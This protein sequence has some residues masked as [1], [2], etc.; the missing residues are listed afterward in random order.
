MDY[1][2]IAPENVLDTLRKYMLVDGFDIVMDL[3]NSQGSYV[4]DLRTGHK[5]LDFFTCIASS[6][7]G[8]NHPKMTTKEFLEKL[9]FIAVN[10]PSNSDIYTVEMAEF[11]D[12]FMTYAAPKL[13]P[14]V[15]FVSGGAL[16]VEN[17]LKTAFDYRI[18]KNIAKG[19]SEK[20]GHKVIHFEDSFHGR[21]GYTLSVTNT[22]DPRKHIYFAKFDW[23][24]FPTPNLSFPITDEIINKVKAKEEKIL[25][26]IRTTIEKDPDDFSCILIEP[27]Q[28]EGGDRHLRA[29]FFQGLQ[30]IAN[31]FDLFLIMD[32][33]QTGMGLTGKWWAYE[34]F[35]IEP[36]IITFGKKSQVCGCLVGKRVEQVEKNVFVES[37]RL[38]STWGGNLIDMVRSQKYIEI[39]TEE[40]LVENARIQG[41]YLREKLCELE[42][43]FTQLNNAR[44]LGLMCA[45]DFP[46]AD[47][48]D[49]VLKQSM[50]NGMF[51]LSCGFS[52]MRFRPPLNISASE[53][54]EGIKILHKSIKEVL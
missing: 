40:N 49:K 53:I 41:D 5:M 24:R 4:V 46:T 51:P 13:L 15:F 25:K 44:G 27:M 14:H 17:A 20:K 26:D 10:K 31:E 7:I 9:A 47:E 23:P 42:K 21:S 52:T 22:N 33:I 38:N 6:P 35:D 18:R 37:S 12:T 36:D 34:H 1:I 48:R 3:K 32:E 11:V 28:A 39:I 19:L 50:K 8:Y 2:K 16:G 54:D 43:D 29:E 30:K 45:I